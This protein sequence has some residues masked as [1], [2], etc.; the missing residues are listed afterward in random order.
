MSN[1]LCPTRKGDVPRKQQ[2]WEAATAPGLEGAGEETALLD[3]WK[4]QLQNSHPM[5]LSRGMQTLPKL[6]RA[7]NGETNTYPDL[8]IL[9][10]SDLQLV[11]PSEK[12]EGKG[13]REAIHRS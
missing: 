8:S 7:G 2:Q 11:L 1:I 3:Q 12:L 6:W 5:T 9:F 10:P 4:L 13:D